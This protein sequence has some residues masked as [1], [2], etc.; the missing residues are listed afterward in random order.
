MI[1]RRT[2]RALAPAAVD[3]AALDRLLARDPVSSVFVA[4][5]VQRVRASGGRPPVYGVADAAGALV[6]AC[7]AGTN[8]VPVALDARGTDLVADALARGGPRFASFF[9]PAEPVL[10]LWQRLRDTWPA[11]FD[12]RPVQPLLVMDRDP[13]PALLTGPAGTVRWGT[14]A[15]AER[16][17]PAAAAMFTEEVGYSPL[18]SGGH[19]YRQRIRSLLREQRTA[20]LTDHR[21]EVVFKADIGSLHAG[22]C[23]IQGVWVAPEHRGRGLAVPCMA[24]AVALARTQAPVVS[25]YVNSYNAPALATYRHVGFE[26]HGDFATVLL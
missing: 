8:V 16:V 24:A 3:P 13:D 22:V 18:T 25:L 14:E 9:G 26:R 6:G 4:S 5:H 1:L 12:V 10:G 19:G 17:V 11:P 23:Q 7:W 2:A 21:G 15:D 20:V